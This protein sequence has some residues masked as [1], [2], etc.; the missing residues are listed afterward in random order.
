MRSATLALLVLVI[1]AGRPA[2]AEWT[3][4]VAHRPTTASAEVAVGLSSLHAD[5]RWQDDRSRPGENVSFVERRW[6]IGA[7]TDLRR[8]FYAGLEVPILQRSLDR[9]DGG[10]VDAERFGPGDAEVAVGWR[11]RPTTAP[12]RGHLEFRWKAPSGAPDSAFGDGS[13]GEP[14]MAPLGTGGH[15]LDLWGGWRLDRARIRLGL[16]AGYRLR[17][18][19][20]AT[21]LWEGILL[22][23]STPHDRLLAQAVFGVRPTAHLDLEAGLES[24]HEVVRQGAQNT[25][26]ATTARLAATVGDGP[27]VGGL[28]VELPVIGRNWPDQAPFAF[29]EREPLVGVR[30]GGW[31]GWRFHEDAR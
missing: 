6:T 31:I 11:S 28:A 21:W 25:S 10:S 16:A 27:W 1:L 14:A 3:P 30:M 7:F 13:L 29:V 23:G 5:G 26:H 24:F 18:P 20:R 12:T 22:G 9:T 19:G 17:T 2:R 15:D 4:L 8:G